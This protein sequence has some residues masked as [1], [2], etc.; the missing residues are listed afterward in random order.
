MPVTVLIVDDDSSFRSL[1]AR[2]V[3]AHGFTVAGEAGDAAKGAIAARS[4]R[5]DAALVDVGLPDGSGIALAGELARLPWSPRVVV[6]S[7]NGDFARAKRPGPNGTQL[8]FVAKDDLAKT[9]LREL[10]GGPE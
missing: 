4:L 8:P 2:M 3:R 5:P 10:L 9:P 1:A 7:S 6:I